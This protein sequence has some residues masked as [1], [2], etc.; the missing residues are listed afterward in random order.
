VFAHEFRFFFER[1][2][3][4]A[5]ACRAM[6]LEDMGEYVAPFPLLLSFLCLICP[7]TQTATASTCV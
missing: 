4:A 5:A 7:G 1:P 3:D 6:F 2:R